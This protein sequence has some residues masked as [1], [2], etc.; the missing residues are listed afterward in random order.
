MGEDIGSTHILENVM[1]QP[2]KRNMKIKCF[3]S[4]QPLYNECVE[5]ISQLYLASRLIKV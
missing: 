1:K 4:N 5:G 3:K 2:M